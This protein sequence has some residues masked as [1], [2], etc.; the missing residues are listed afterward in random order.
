MANTVYW[1]PNCQVPII[2]NEICPLCGA[3][4]KPISTTGVC[5][6]VFRQEKKLLSFILDDDVTDK[7]VWYLGSSF[8]LIDGKRTKLPYIDFY[9][10]K[11]HLTI[12]EAL[13]SDISDDVAIPRLNTF[14]AANEQYLKEL[15]Y[16]AEEYVVDLVNELK[17]DP[18]TNY[19]PTVSFSGGKD[20]T[21]VS[22]VV[23]DALQNESIIH[24]FGDTTLEFP[25]TH[26]YVEEAF[27]KENRFTPM[28]PSETDNDFFKL[29]NVFGPPSKFE[30]W[31]CTIF[32]TSNMNMIDKNVSIDD[33]D[34]VD[35]LSPISL[36]A[37]LQ[38]VSSQETDNNHTKDVAGLLTVSDIKEKYGLSSDYI[39][40]ALLAGTIVPAKLTLYFNE[41]DVERIVAESTTLNPLMNAFEKELDKMA[42]NYSYK[43]L[44][45]LA[46]FE[47]KDL[48]ATAEDIV[49]FYFN[50]YSKRAENQ[51]M[52]EKEDSSF[53][54]NPGNR[55]IAR[56]TILRYPVSVL[57]KRS[58]V[59]YDKESDTIK[60]NP[61]LVKG[62]NRF[63]VEF[64]KNQCRSLLAKYY[65]SIQK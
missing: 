12:A 39:N 46:L 50:Y 33:F 44:L 53:V 5:N 55:I 51:L 32:K 42:M 36:L 25:C 6:P 30:R 41:D 40:S 28:I 45:L 18:S 35:F 52:I 64:A 2:K 58:F 23:R 54:Q 60:L 11:K 16:E 34:E 13:R 15:I 43:P 59:L 31:C 3:A 62:N 21:V 56:R 24:Y 26:A 49:T 10:K 47:S 8:Y 57:A 22:R 19:M 48:S 14:L 61:L 63:N 37:A 7:N 27:R 65:E 1:C 17:N 20:S 4:S 9:K 29:C 38:K